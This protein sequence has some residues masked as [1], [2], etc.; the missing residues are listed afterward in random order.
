M[1]ILGIIVERLI[2]YLD[3]NGVNPGRL[4]KKN[5]GLNWILS[6]YQKNKNKNRWPD[7]W[8]VGVSD[9]SNNRFDNWVK[10]DNRPAPGGTWAGSFPSMAR[11][12]EKVGDVSGT[13][14]RRGQRK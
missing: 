13:G 5:W 1:I 2:T 8:E 10:L 6:G 12:K 9:R 7:G 11:K 4:L 14:V 3:D